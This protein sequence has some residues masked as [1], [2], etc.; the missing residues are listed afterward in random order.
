MAAAKNLAKPASMLLTSVI[1]NIPQPKPDGLNINNPY[2]LI[3][4]LQKWTSQSWFHL[5][6]FP[7]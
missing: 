4:Y 3:A 7:P 5:I 2:P 1:M 6:H